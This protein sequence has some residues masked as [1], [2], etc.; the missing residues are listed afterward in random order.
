MITAANRAALTFFLQENAMMPMAATK[1]KK[2]LECSPSRDVKAE[3][4]DLGKGVLRPCPVLPVKL[5]RFTVFEEK[6]AGE[7]LLHGGLEGAAKEEDG[8]CGAGD[9]EQCTYEPPP[10]P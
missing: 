10:S 1:Q 3:L 7:K 6:E 8:G 9:D 5:R 2:K 4:L